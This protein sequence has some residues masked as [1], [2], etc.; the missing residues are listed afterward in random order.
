[1]YSKYLLYICIKNTYKYWGFGEFWNLPL[2]RIRKNMARY[3]TNTYVRT[4]IRK[5][6]V[7]KE[8]PWT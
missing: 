7:V 5:A 4:E 1:M 3:A 2:E 8:I 6:E